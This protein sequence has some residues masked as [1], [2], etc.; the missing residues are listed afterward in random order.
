M[1]RPLGQSRDAAVPAREATAYAEDYF[2]WV[3]DQVALLRA[4]RRDQLDLDNLAEEVGDLGNSVKREIASR[5]EVLLCHLLKWQF[6][7]AH[8]SNSWKATIIEQRRRIL[9]ELATSPSLK[10]YP[11]KVLDEEY[12][13]ARLKASG[14]THLSESVFPHDCPFAIADI[15]DPDFFPE[16]EA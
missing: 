2:A 16:A 14:E 12:E 11:A 8:Q 10:G 9:H 13:T 5:L 7:P 4:G 6:Q 3:Q 1:S 15:L